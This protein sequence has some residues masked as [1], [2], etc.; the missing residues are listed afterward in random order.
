MPILYNFKLVSIQLLQGIGLFDFWRSSNLT[1]PGPEA[2]I[3][4]ASQFSTI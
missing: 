4:T 1:K 3:S 2:Q